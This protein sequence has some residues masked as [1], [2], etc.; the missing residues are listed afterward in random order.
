M[1]SETSK[2][3]QAV[4]TNQLQMVQEM[5]LFTIPVTQ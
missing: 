5:K 3:T 1:I 2:L 4:P